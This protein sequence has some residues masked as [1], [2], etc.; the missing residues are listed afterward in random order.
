MRRTLLKG[1]LLAAAS[2]MPGVALA[3]TH[4]RSNLGDERL[5][6]TWRSDKQRTLAHWQFKDGIDQKAKETIS[7]WFGKL[8][9]TFS[10]AKVVTVFED[11]RFESRY[12]VIARTESSVTLEYQTEGRSEVDTIYYGSG[13]MFKRVGTSVNFEYFTK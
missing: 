8:T 11:G 2:K 5:L 10:K 4:S 7:A 9:H 6:G 13:Y 1:L 12:R 3:N